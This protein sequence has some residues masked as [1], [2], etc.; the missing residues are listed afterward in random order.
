VRTNSNEMMFCF[1]RLV[2]CALCVVR[3]FVDCC[4]AFVMNLGKSKGDVTMRSSAITESR[5]WLRAHAG[6]N[7]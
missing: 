3:C 4:S 1:C 5:G 6:D 2:R 7:N